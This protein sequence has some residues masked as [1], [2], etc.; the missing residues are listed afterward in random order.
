MFYWKAAILRFAHIY[1]VIVMS[2][3][4]CLYSFWYAWKEETHIYTM[5]PLDISGIQNSSS[6][7]AVSLPW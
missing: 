2:Y 6:Q 5:V 1:D 3:V 7:G 4:G